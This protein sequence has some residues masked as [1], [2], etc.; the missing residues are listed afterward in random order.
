[1]LYRVSVDYLLNLADSEP[2]LFDNARVE[3]PE[4]LELYDELTPAQQQNILNYARGMVVS[5]QL[6]STSTTKKRRA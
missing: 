5:N 1:M 2:Q 3:R 4:I 6:E